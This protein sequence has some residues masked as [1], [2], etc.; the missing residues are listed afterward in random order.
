MKK[1]KREL[2]LEQLNKRKK[3]FNSIS[4][5][6]LFIALIG[7]IIIGIIIC[8]FKELKEET[9][10]Q[11]QTV[12]LIYAIFW[13]VMAVVTN[14]ISSI[15]KKKIQTSIK[16]MKVT[17]IKEKSKECDLKKS[18]TLKDEKIITDIL[19]KNIVKI[20]ADN[21]EGP[22]LVTSIQLADTTWQCQVYIPAEKLISILDENTKKE[23]LEY[24]IKDIKIRNPEGE[25]TEVTI[26]GYYCGNPDFCYYINQKTTDEELL[27]MF[28]LKEE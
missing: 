9:V 17:A 10:I 23:M 28:E 16:T 2:T 12:Y 26:L 25:T 24:L 27:E 5:K 22:N 13:I 8:C 1:E 15:Y 4:M 3:I 11:L 14:K 7:C 21:I 18:V 19:S 6:S 20:I